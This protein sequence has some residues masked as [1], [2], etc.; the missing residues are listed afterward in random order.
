LREACSARRLTRMSEAR[1]FRPPVSRPWPS[2]FEFYGMR[3]YAPGD[4]VRR[5][6]WRAFARPGQLLVREA[7]QGI[8]DRVTILLDQD[9]T[10]H[11]KGEVSGSF[12]AAVRV[13][14]SVGVRDL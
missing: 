2:G 10:H 12:E 13:A 14:G 6:V 8:V 7:E 11:A 5:V 4:D 9:V 3:Q 1:P